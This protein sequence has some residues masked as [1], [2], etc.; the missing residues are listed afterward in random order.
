MSRSRRKPVVNMDGSGSPYLRRLSHRRRRA[1]ERSHGR[2]GDLR[3]FMD[4]SVDRTDLGKWG[5]EF[6]QDAEKARR[7]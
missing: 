5:P 4:D 6:A 3:Q 7:K 1:Y 2:E